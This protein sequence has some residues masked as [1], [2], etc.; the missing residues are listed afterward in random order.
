MNEVPSGTG[1]S[2]TA[3]GLLDGVVTTGV[4]TAAGELVVV[5]TGVTTAGGGL[6]VVVVVV[7]GYDVVVT[8]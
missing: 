2:G 1:H 4:T 5:T 3:D 6:V 8:S 7:V